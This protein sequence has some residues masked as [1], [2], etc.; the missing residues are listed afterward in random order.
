LCGTCR[1]RGHY[2]GAKR[3]REYAVRC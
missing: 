3:W 1:H 2:T